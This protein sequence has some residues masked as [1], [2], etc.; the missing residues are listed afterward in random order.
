MLG[1][2]I[3]YPSLFLWVWYGLSLVS[4]NLVHL[5]SQ[6][7]S[8]EWPP[9]SHLLFVGLLRGH[10]V[11][12]KWTI[13]PVSENDNILGGHFLECFGL[14]DKM[15]K[16]KGLS[17]HVER[18]CGPAKVE[19]RVICRSYHAK[20]SLIAGFAAFTAEL[21]NHATKQS[22]AFFRTCKF[23]SYNF[24]NLPDPWLLKISACDSRH[25]SRGL[26]SIVLFQEIGDRVPGLSFEACGVVSYFRLFGHFV[27]EIDKICG[28]IWSKV[29]G[30]LVATYEFFPCL[31]HLVH[32]T[33]ECL[34]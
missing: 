7:S 15:G 3:E 9:P 22:R 33:F 6:I 1:R 34:A 23:T 5:Q 29:E 2:T 8:R 31:V 16:I 12:R 21:N 18:I 20:S 19:N 32:R 14:F 11:A 27:V 26:S 25:R 24:H 10:L 4:C 17:E 28:K 30:K 13:I